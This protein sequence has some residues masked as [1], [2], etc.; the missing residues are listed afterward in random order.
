MIVICAWCRESQ[1][2]KEPL[3]NPAITHGMCD[4]CFKG[5]AD[6]VAHVTLPPAMDNEF[7]DSLYAELRPQNPVCQNG[8]TGQVPVV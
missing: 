8:L 2:E 4:K 3:S 1:G 5:L 7:F 6:E